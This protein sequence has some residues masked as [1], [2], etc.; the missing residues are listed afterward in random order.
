MNLRVALLCL[1]VA[2]LVL[3][4][5]WAVRLPRVAS[6]E[7][8][9]DAA[10]EGDLKKVKALVAAGADVNA[11]SEMGTSLSD[12]ENASS[13][14]IQQN[15]DGTVMLEVT[16]QSHMVE[17]SIFGRKV[18]NNGVR[19]WVRSSTPLHAALE[20]GHDD[21]AAYLL[22]VGAD[23][24]AENDLGTT[25]LVDAVYTASPEIGQ[26]ILAA[27]VDVNAKDDSGD[28]P[29]HH[30][31]RADRPENVEVLLA[32]GADPGTTNKEGDTPLDLSRSFGHVRIV[33][34]I[35]RHMGGL[36]AAP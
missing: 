15:P 10:W 34:I 35:E 2:I 36:E 28:T 5:V 9:H 12:I 11:R 32:S 24:N 20:G 31:V 30:A 1:G 6:P 14:V 13:R 3:V 27:G 8:L 29:L 22:R 18:Y 19:F 16:S 26:A 4:M 23:V 25:P 17:W 21:V 33:E 7:P